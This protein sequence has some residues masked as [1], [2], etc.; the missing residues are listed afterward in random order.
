[1][2]IAQK[3]RWVRVLVPVAYGLA[4]VSCGFS[5]VLGLATLERLLIGAASG[6]LPVGASFAPVRRA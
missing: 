6:R 2:D 4:T 5:G 1:M 3:I